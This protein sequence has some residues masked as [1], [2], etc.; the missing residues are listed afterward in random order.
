MARIFL[1]NAS[2]KEFAP[3]YRNLDI[4]VPGGLINILADLKVANNVVSLDLTQQNKNLIVLK[5]KLS[6]QMNCDLKAN[7]QYNLN[8]KQFGFSG[9]AAVT[10]SKVEGI[11]FLGPVNEIKGDLIFNNSGIFSNN[12]NAKIWELPVKA[13]ASLTN[14]NDALLNINIFS[15]MALGTVERLLRERL[16][17]NL[18]G[19]VMGQGS[20]YVGLQTKFAADEKLQIHGW[21]DIFNGTLKFNKIASPLEDMRG[22]IEFERNQAK[23]TDLNFIYQGIPYNSKCVITDFKSPGVQFALSS[24]DLS[25]DSVLAVNN[26]LVTLTKLD[27]RYLNSTFSVSGDINT[28]NPDSPDADLSGSM[29]LDLEDASKP[30]LKNIIY[31]IEKIKPAGLVHGQFQLYGNIT[32]L[33]T[34][35]IEAKFASPE[36][37]VYGLKAQEFF[38]NYSQEEGKAN[39]P[40]MHMSLYGGTLDSSASMDLN[41]KERPYWISLDMKGVEIEK[42]KLDT[43]AKDKDVSGTVQAQATINGIYKDISRLSGGGK[44]LITDGKLWQLN[45]FKGMGAL[46][47]TKDFTNIVFS[48]GQCSFAIKDESISTDRLKLKSNIVNLAG[49]VRI[50]FDKSITASLDV[51][52]LDEMVPLSGTF[53][54]VTTAIVGKAGRFGV[55]EISGTLKDPKYKFKSSVKDFIKGIKNT[56]FH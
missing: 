24:E 7:L 47:F 53:R 34:C 30:L 11:D 22:R 23:W 56:F 20:L 25:L 48:E 26:K 39:F 40:L 15:D 1:Q 41:S 36:V 50:G 49:P 44:I 45:L 35:N 55:I 21:L 29:D 51:E 6:F 2:P 5:E 16:K 3:Y 19:N 18:P 17:F 46:L 32:D 12:L 9:K 14:F 10:D 43:P 42:L 31:R 8:D 38:L 54:D 4:S 37:F 28:Q 13:K 33:K 52:V 27:G